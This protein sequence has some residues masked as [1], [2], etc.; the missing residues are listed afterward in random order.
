MGVLNSTLSQSQKRE[1]QDGPG[2]IYKTRAREM[3]EDR[4]MTFDSLIRPNHPPS[5]PCMLRPVR[6]RLVL[7]AC[8]AIYK[9]ISRISHRK[10]IGGRSRGLPCLSGPDTVQQRNG[11][12]RPPPSPG[13]RRAYLGIWTTGLWSC[14]GARSWCLGGRSRSTAT[15]KGNPM[16]HYSNIHDSTIDPSLHPSAHPPSAHVRLAFS[17]TGSRA[18]APLPSACGVRR[19]GGWLAAGFLEAEKRR[20]SITHAAHRA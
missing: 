5:P 10:P 2:I 8:I 11:I 18:Q 9:T 19:W 3:E 7:R 17:E 12:V 16:A 14:G 15:A 4:D 6:L 20:S 13:R 1:P